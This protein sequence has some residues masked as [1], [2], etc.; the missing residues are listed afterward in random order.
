MATMQLKA[1]PATAAGW[2]CSTPVMVASRESTSVVACST[3]T[4][5][6]ILR[7]DRYLDVQRILI[8]LQNEKPEIVQ[9][10][11]NFLKSWSHL[12]QNWPKPYRSEPLDTTEWELA[13]PMLPRGD[14][15]PPSKCL[16]P[17]SGVRS[18][19]AAMSLGLRQSSSAIGIFVWR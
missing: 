7:F 17:P 12:A 16:W 9:L 3:N 11:S 14:S 2:S 5:F 4:S 8:L 19:S 6:I 18:S 13:P 15:Y 10:Y 1:H